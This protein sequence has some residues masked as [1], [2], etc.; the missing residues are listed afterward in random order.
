MQTIDTVDYYL[1]DVSSKLGQAVN[2]D[3]DP[4]FHSGEYT[5]TV[6]VVEDVLVDG[7]IL[8]NVINTSGGNVQV[9]RP[10]LILTSGTGVSN[11]SQEECTLTVRNGTFGTLDTVITFDSTLSDAYGYFDITCPGL[12]NFTT[13]TLLKFVFTGHGVNQ[14]TEALVDQVTG[15]ALLGTRKIRVRQ[16]LGPTISQSYAITVSIAYGFLLEPVITPVTFQNP[17]TGIDLGSRVLNFGYITTPIDSNLVQASV[18]FQVTRS[19]F[20]ESI[21]IVLPNV[22]TDFTSR[23]KLTTTAHAVLDSGI[24]ADNVFIESVPND[25]VAR[26]GFLGESGSITI[27]FTIGYL[28]Q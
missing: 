12:G 19:D 28:S 11:I 20:L 6:H 27:C 15:T 24:L 17:S 16:L 4:T 1:K 18:T 13:E 25:Q 26:L 8:G 22:T 23:F 2:T 9:T 5:G 3:S 21:D 10:N 7:I 14:D